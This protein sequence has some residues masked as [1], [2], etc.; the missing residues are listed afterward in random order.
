MT[1][2]HVVGYHTVSSLF[3]TTAKWF[4]SLPLY[5]QGGGAEMLILQ[6]RQWEVVS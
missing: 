5:L 6:Q 1:V 3:W 2:L 4:H